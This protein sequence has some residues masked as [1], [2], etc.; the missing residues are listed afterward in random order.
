MLSHFVGR[1]VRLEENSGALRACEKCDCKSAAIARADNSHGIVT[2]FSV[3]LDCGHSVRPMDQGEADTLEIQR[4]KR[5]RK[6][7]KA[8]QNG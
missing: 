4:T 1:K 7:E 3:V 8:P 2:A 5:P 6:I